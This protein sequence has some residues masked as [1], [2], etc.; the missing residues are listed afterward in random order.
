MRSNGK[1]TSKESIPRL[2]PF[3]N[4]IKMKSKKHPSRKSNTNQ[5]PNTEQKSGGK[6]TTDQLESR[7][8]KKIKETKTKNS[9]EMRSSFVFVLFFFA[10]LERFTRRCGGRDR[11][12]SWSGGL[13]KKKRNHQKTI[14]H[15]A[16]NERRHET[17]VVSSNRREETFGK[18]RSLKVFSHFFIDGWLG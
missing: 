12:S 2:G 7:R 11:G 15:V 10:F 14:N 1:T 4:Q 17:W 8:R 13:A 6:K 16:S 18:Q 9:L 5:Q 3:Q